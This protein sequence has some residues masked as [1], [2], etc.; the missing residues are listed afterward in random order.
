M[1]EVTLEYVGSQNEVDSGVITVIVHVAT[2]PQSVGVYVPGIG[3]ALFGFSVTVVV[4]GGTT[5]TV[6][7][8]A[9]PQSVAVNVPGEGSTLFGLSVT[10]VV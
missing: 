7:V 3:W 6:Q 2:S 4:C 10:V 9:Y 5:T 8:S 1:E